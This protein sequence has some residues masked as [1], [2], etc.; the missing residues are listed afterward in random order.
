MVDGY[1]GDA[2]D[3]LVAQA[4]PVW[5]SN[6][7]MFSTPD[8]DN[9]LHSTWHCGFSD[10]WWYRACSTDNVNK[11][12]NAVWQVLGAQHDVEAARMLVKMN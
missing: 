9:D 6:G 11:V 1:S 3:A 10:G 7:M 8:S 5:I 4:D 12:T 2:G